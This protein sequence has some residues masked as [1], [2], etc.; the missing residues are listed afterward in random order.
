VIAAA[1]RCAHRQERTGAQRRHHA[2]SA[3]RGTAYGI[4]GVGMAAS[5]AITEPEVMTSPAQKRICGPVR[6]CRQNAPGHA[7]L[8]TATGGLQEIAGNSAEIVFHRPKSLR[9]TTFLSLEIKRLRQ[10][11]KSDS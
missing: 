9:V 8:A 10:L 2:T 6:A 5:R 7:D 1:R 3:A 4:L 11:S